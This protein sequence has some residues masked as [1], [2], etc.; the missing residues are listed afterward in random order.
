MNTSILWRPITAIPAYTLN[1]WLS[2]YL[3]VMR[4]N[5]INFPRPVKFCCV[6]SER[7]SKHFV[8]RE[9]TKLCI[10]TWF[11]NHKWYRILSTF[12]SPSLFE[13]YLQCPKLMMFQC[14]RLF[15]KKTCCFRNKYLN[16][17]SVKNSIKKNWEE[18]Y[19]LELQNSVLSPSCKQVWFWR[20]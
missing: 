13:S 7:H 12:P 4:A 8:K 1:A 18:R 16:M 19:G 14:W 20:V 11:M 5:W 10:F 6:N 17:F 15:S 9:L 2:F 3:T